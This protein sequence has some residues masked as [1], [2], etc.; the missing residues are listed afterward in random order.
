M[1]EESQ[2]SL[3][4]LFVLLNIDDFVFK[5]ALETELKSWKKKKKN[6]KNKTISFLFMLIDFQNITE[7]CPN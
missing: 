1:I 4:A 2:V 6:I 3:W 7:L 5:N